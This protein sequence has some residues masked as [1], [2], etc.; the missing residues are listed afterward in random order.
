MIH[1]SLLFFAVFFLFL[2][3]FPLSAEIV[4][5]CVAVVNND[6]ITLSEV[7]EIGLPIFK[8]VAEQT[9]PDQLQ[10]VLKQAR[11]T[12]I[13]KL[14]EKKLL[15]QEA[16][17]Y[18]ITVTDEEVD[19]ALQRILASNNATMEQFRNQ[20][21][22]MGL[23]EKQYKEDLKGQILSSKLVNIAVRS[24]VIVPEEEIIDYYDMH[25]TEQVGDGGYYILQI[26]I[27][28]D[29]NS[30]TTALKTAKEEAEKKIQRVRSLAV[31]DKDFKE[32]ARQYSD[33]P[34]A[35]DGGDIGVFREEEMASVMRDAVIG[36]QPGQVSEI[37]ETSSGYQIFK[38]L[39]SQE[40][41]IVTK[42]PYESVK[43][44]IRE[45]L[46]QQKMQELYKNWMKG[47][48]EQAYIK[49]L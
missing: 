41:Q 30:D 21:T 9:P 23:S 43:E 35:A 22:T 14:I 20:L 5:R 1:K 25:Y 13:E 16:K 27:T 40:G 8:R 38:L 11:A 18:N 19:M 42:V 36:L 29:R 31:T 44:E 39:S 3:P 32:L 34:S 26:G 47:I 45:T 24:K 17:K 12:V 15:L 7:N 37:V 6:I 48:R 49:T 28:W 4:D 46:Y 2:Q 10:E 33:L